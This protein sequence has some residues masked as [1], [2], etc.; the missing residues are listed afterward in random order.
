MHDRFDQPAADV[1]THEIRRQATVKGARD[2]P[3][4]GRAGVAAIRSKLGSWR[5]I[6]VASD[7]GQSRLRPAIQMA[8]S[9]IVAL[10]VAYIFIQLAHPDWMS[11][12]STVHVSP[13]LLAKLHAQHHGETLIIL[14]SFGTVTFFARRGRR[15]A[16]GA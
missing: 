15:R 12:A 5:D 6:V 10:P 11:A 4:G 16:G 2:H 7:P 3:G 9:F 8:L 1:A 13:S 14:V